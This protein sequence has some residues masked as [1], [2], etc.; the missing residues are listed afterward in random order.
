M[1]LI[2]GSDGRQTTSNTSR[3]NLDSVTNERFVTEDA[4][5]AKNSKRVETGK[6][7]EPAQPARDTKI[8]ISMDIMYMRAYLAELRQTPKDT[9]KSDVKTAVSLQILYMRAYLRSKR[10]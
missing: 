10:K 9:M 6:A 5:A 8:A 3:Q 7:P 2:P 1:Q 4:V